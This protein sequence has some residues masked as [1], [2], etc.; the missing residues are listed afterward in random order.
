MKPFS[1]LILPTVFN[2]ENVSPGF[3]TIL[4]IFLNITLA[5]YILFFDDLANGV[6]AV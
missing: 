5:L 1:V 6:V 2:K 3:T 4:F